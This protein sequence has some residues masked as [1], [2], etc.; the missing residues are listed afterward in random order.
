MK[1]MKI[2]L[3]FVAGLSLV[4]C[5]K[6]DLTPVPDKVGV[7]VRLDWGSLPVAPGM[8]YSFYP[9]GGGAAITEEG[10]GESYTGALPSG[11]YRILAYNAGTASVVFTGMDSYA[12]ATA[13]AVPA[14][15]STRADG[16]TLIEQPSM[17]YAGTSSGELV[18]P[19]LDPV[20]TSAN[21]AQLTRTLKLTFKLNDIEGVNSLEGT[22]NGAY[23]SVLLGT[24]EFTASAQASAPLTAV[25]FASEVTANRISTVVSFFGVKNPE[26]GVAYRS[27]LHLTLKGNDGWNRQVEADL[28]KALTDIY[29]IGGEDL[30][31]EIPTSIDIKVEPTPVAFSAQV[32]AWRLGEGS[33]EIEYV[34]N[35]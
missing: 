19:R 6:E 27:T 15:L 5:T 7:T 24:G 12:T 33:G 14:A 17:L 31:F 13:E 21:A 30:A 8:T 25:T 20:E 26:G 3:L 10:T 11:S 32:E 16:I 34:Y 28:T 35:Y 18:V 22:F 1:G 2:L 9:T 29:A 23:P 4:A